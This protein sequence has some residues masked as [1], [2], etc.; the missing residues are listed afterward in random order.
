VT[1]KGDAEIAHEVQAL[2]RLDLE[3]LRDVWR[4]RWGVAPKIRSPELLRLMIAWRIQ[5]EAYGALDAATRRRLRTGAAIGRRDHVAVG[6]VITKEWRGRTYRVARTERGYEWEGRTF[7]S[8]SRVAHA[9][10]G[11][12]RNGPDFFGLR[13]EDGA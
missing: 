8:L 4:R 6:I 2:D 10:T 11:V 7:A 9:M 13:G 12:K 5:S 1:A 3:G